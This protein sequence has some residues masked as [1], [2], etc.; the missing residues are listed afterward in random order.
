MLRFSTAMLIFAIP[1]CAI[2]KL[3]ET[4]LRL[5]IAV[6]YCA[7][8]CLRYA[9]PSC[10]TPLHR[11]AQ[12]HSALLRLYWA[13]P[14][15]TKQHSALAA[16][17]KLNHTLHYHHVSSLF[18]YRA[19]LYCA[20]AGLLFNGKYFESSMAAISPLSYSGIFSVCEPF[21]YSLFISIRHNRDNKGYA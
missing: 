21:S 5:Y 12:N 6:R 17:D 15:K 18:H 7:M 9:F 3:S 4:R 16:Q 2:T 13:R 8:L 11:F 10:A 14:L 19:L 1:H 20:F